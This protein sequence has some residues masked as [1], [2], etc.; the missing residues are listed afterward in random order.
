VTLA[1]DA[2]ALAARTRAAQGQPGLVEDPAALAKVAAILAGAE[3]GV[4][5]PRPEVRQGPQEGLMNGEGAL[6]GPHTT[7]TTLAT[8]ANGSRSQW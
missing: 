1:D 7:V 3:R 8:T 6:S 5:R 2:R 4:H